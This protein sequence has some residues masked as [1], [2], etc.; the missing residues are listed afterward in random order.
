MTIATVSTSG[1]H[2]R[3]VRTR[4]DDIDPD[5]W[6]SLLGPDDLQL[7]HRFVRVCQESGIEDAVYRFVVVE[8]AAGPAC[9]AA[10][11]SFAVRLELLAARRLRRAAALVRRWHDDF[12]RL[13]VVFCGLPVSFGRPCVRFRPGADRTRCIAAVDA[14]MADMARA[15]DA[16]LLC[17]KE[18]D[19]AEAAD[20][21]AL[22]GAGYFRA[23]SLPSC[24]LDL[25]WTTFD[26]YL[27]GMRAPYRRQVVRA[28]RAAD[29]AGLTF[30][31]VRDFGPRCDALGALYGQVMDRAEFQLERLDHR[32]LENLDRLFPDEASVIVA[33]RRGEP[34]AMAVLLDAPGLCAFLLA[35]I[36]YARNRDTGA[37]VNLVAEVVAHA[38]RRGVAVLEMGQTSYDLKRRLGAVTTPR[39]LFLRHRS[40]AMHR[41][42]ARLGGFLFP[43][44]A[45]PGRHVFRVEERSVAA[46]DASSGRR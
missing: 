17:W 24:R 22:R 11:S 19:A 36:D 26:A 25:R 13:R 34:V 21:A 44:R 28:R 18:F 5:V 12:L 4:I 41:V 32:F 8:D 45:Y 39:Y 3:T 16:P 15:L 14:V 40:R 1:A 2:R 37:Y 38:I 42:L 7:S 27:S 35:G 31:A 29:A 46:G 10:L 33:E 23:A 9:V 20:V 43:E 6:D 30:R